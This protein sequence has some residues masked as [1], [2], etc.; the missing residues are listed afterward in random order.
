MAVTNPLFSGSLVLFELGMAR[1][2]TAQ[3]F[4]DWRAITC[5]VASAVLIIAFIVNERLMGARAMVQGHIFKKKLV[6]TTMVYQSFLAGLFF[7]LNFL[8]PIQFQSV[9][10]ASAKQ[11]GIR[12]IPLILAVSVFTLVANGVLTFWRKF[13]PMLMFGAAAGTVGVAMIRTLGADTGTGFW[14]AYKILVGLGVGVVLQVPMVANQAAVGAEDVAAVTALTLFVENIATTLFTTT[15]ESVLTSGLLRALSTYVPEVDPQMVVN[16]GATQI[17]ESFGTSQ[18][19]GVIRSYLEGCRQSQLVPLTC[20]SAA[21]I[22]SL[23]LGIPELTKHLAA[24][25]RKAA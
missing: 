14:V 9:D 2:T 7:P 1:G 17:Q 13:T 10:N 21:A 15:A 12:L 24:R 23:F 22:V 16:A 19:H 3:G 25:L 6:R 18:V 8:L 20:G 4:K 11:S 5:L